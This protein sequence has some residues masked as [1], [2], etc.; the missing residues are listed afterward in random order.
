MQV[1]LG[2]VFAI[3]KGDAARTPWV[4]Y[5][6]FRYPRSIFSSLGTK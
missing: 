4:V 2:A 5:F 3:R 6:V 1:F